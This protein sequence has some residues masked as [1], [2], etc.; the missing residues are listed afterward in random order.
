MIVKNQAD[1]VRWME[2]EEGCGRDGAFCS[3]S[4]ATAKMHVAVGNEGRVFARSPILEPKR[5]RLASA[6]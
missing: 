6:A 1:V 3:V 2:Q 5:L 4:C